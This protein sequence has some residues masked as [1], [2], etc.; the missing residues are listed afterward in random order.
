VGVWGADVFAGVR[1]LGQP[2]VLTPVGVDADDMVRHH[3]MDEAKLF[4]AR[5]PLADGARVG[6][7][8]A[9]WK[10]HAEPSR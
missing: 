10:Y 8:L 2:V 4:H 9:C 7:D 6:T 1:P 3:D 5:R